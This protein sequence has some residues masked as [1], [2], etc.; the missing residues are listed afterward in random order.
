MKSMLW[1]IILISI[2]TFIAGV[3]FLQA[4]TE[5]LQDHLGNIPEDKQSQ[6]SPTGVVYQQP[7]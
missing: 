6:S 1:A 7:C 2:I 4:A 3:A 5:Y